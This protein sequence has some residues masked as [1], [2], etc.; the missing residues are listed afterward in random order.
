MRMHGLILSLKRK[1][2]LGAIL[3]GLSIA[4]ID[5]RQDMGNTV[6]KVPH[7]VAVGVKVARPIPIAVEIAV[8]LESVVAVNRNHQLDAMAGCLDH[9]AIQAL[10]HSIVPAAGVGSFEA[11]VWVDVG[12]LLA[13]L[14]A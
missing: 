4:G 5:M 1:D 12:A 3:P 9:E 7:G 10:Q 13:V 14:L 2:I 11:V 8:S 6:L